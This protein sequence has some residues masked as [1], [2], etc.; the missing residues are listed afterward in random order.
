[1][2][3]VQGVKGKR[4]QPLGKNSLNSILTNE[5]YIGVYTWN[6]RFQKKFGKWA[7]GKPNPNCARKEGAIP[8][9]VESE[10]WER[11]QTRMGDNSKKATN[12]AKHEYLLSGLIECTNCGSTYVGHCST[13]KRGYSTRYYCCGGR[14]RTRTCTAKNINADEIET[15]V[16][17][18]LKAYFLETDFED[19]A[20]RIADEVNNASEDLTREKRELADIVLQINN[21]MKAIMRGME[22]PELEEEIGHLRVRKGELEDIIARKESGRGKVNPAKIIDLFNAS[23]KN[24]DV[25]LKN[26][27]KYHIDKI[28]ANPDGSYAV[29]VGVHIMV[30]GAGFGPATFGL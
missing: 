28:Y 3:A 12:K 24:W 7:G 14:Y 16:V 29:N 11:V 9:I 17:Q 22:F 20:Q 23:M 4:G 5:R 2:D 30:A 27:I 19:V 18:Q 8:A 6:K 25:D 15:F 1:L 10:L 13:N 21:G 26:I